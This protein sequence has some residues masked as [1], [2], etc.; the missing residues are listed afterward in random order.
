MAGM[1][2]WVCTYLHASITFGVRGI[3]AMELVVLGIVWT[4]IEM[5]LASSVGAYLY[6]EEAPVPRTATRS[7]RPPI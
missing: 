7:S 1:F 6:K 5:I 4:L 2:M 3:N